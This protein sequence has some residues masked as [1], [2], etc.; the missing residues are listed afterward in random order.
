M[1]TKYQVETQLACVNALLTDDEKETLQM[2]GYKE[3]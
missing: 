2:I 3:E 1:G